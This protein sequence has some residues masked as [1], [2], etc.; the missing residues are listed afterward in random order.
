MRFMGRLTISKY[1]GGAL[2]FLIMTL[3]GLPQPGHFIAI[4]FNMSGFTTDFTSGGGGV[5]EPSSS[6]GLGRFAF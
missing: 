1:P 2:L 6:A 3:K 5:R 4:S